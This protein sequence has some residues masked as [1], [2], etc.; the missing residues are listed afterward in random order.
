MRCATAVLFALG[1]GG[2]SRLASDRTGE[3]LFRECEFKAAA[4]FLRACVDERTWQRTSPL[5]A[6][7]VVCANGRGVGS[8]LGTQ[9]RA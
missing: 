4:Q 2:C 3:A 8:I 7:Q 1:V 9:E 5:L 6:R